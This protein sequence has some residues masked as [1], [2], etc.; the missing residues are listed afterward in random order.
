M[1]ASTPP[2]RRQFTDDN[3]IR[4]RQ[5]K[6]GTWA[7][8][9]LW[10]DRELGHQSETFTEYTRALSLKRFLR[11]NHNTLSL[12]LEAKRQATHEVPSVEEL[13]TR[14]ITHNRDI[15]EGSRSDQLSMVANHLQDTALGRSSVDRVADEDITA[16]VDALTKHTRKGGDTGIPLG[17]KTRANIHAVVSAAFSEAVSRGTISR[18]PARGAINTSGVEREQPTYLSRDQIQAIIDTTPAGYQPLVWTLA[19][20]GLRWGEATALQ[21]RDLQFQ[22]DGRCLVHIRRA[23]KRWE[24]GGLAIGSTKTRNSVR[25]ITA[26]KD[27]SDTLREQARGRGP[28]EW[29]F[30]NK[31][32]KPVRN[33][34]FNR[35]TW[36]PTITRLLQDRTL[37]ERPQLKWLRHMHCT[38]LLQAGVPIHV[39]QARLGHESPST[40]LAIYARIMRHDDVQAVEMIENQRQ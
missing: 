11:A 38:H 27:L 29:V 40:T 39:V 16:W 19:D 37:D 3:G 33:N 35:K 7:Y 32:D 2:T 28:R 26:P 9:V 34:T 36:A 8:T 13:V 5:R 12:A 20:L 6:D 23:W 14:H 10:R 30:T 17:P 25:S 24:D 21:A 1:S 15:T 18:N 31:H 4:H 22:D